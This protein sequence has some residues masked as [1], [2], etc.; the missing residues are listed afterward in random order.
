MVGQPSFVLARADLAGSA[1]TGTAS[2]PRPS[3]RRGAG[4]DDD[5]EAAVYGARIRPLIR[6]DPERDAFEWNLMKLAV[7]AG[8]PVLGIRRNAQMINLHFGGGRDRRAPRQERSLRVE[9]ATGAS[10]ENGSA[11]S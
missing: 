4:W 6:I 7:T 8:L 10:R 11:Y 1:S 2:A 9:R 3:R 5:V